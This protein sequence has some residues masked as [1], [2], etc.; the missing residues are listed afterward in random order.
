[1]GSILKR[2]IGKLERTIR[3]ARSSSKSTDLGHF[4]EQVS[5]HM[6]RT[7]ATFDEA[8]EALMQ[9]LSTE[10][11]HAILAQTEPHGPVTN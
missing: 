11:L 9:M 10:Q 4:L 3:T 2:R 7:G 1:M 8:V 6:H 5:E